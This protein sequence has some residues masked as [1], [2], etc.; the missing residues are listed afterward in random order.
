[1]IFGDSISKEAFNKKRGADNFY[2]LLAAEHDAFSPTVVNA[3]IGGETLDNALIRMDETLELNPDIQYI[4]VA[5]GTNDAWGN[6]KTP[7]GVRFEEKLRMVVDAILDAGRTP[8]LA[9]IP[10]GSEFHAGVP[11]FNTVIDQLQADY[12]LPCGPDLFTH[13]YENQG[14]LS[15]DNVHPGPA[16]YIAINRLWAEAVSPLYQD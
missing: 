9:R 7:Q 12:E 10:H 5:F 13:F 1:M 8:V 11:A 16:G 6:T 15:G 4:G 14:D 2:R 3:S